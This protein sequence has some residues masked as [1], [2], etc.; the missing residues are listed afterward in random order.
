ML[1]EDKRWCGGIC[2]FDDD[3][4]GSLPNPTQSVYYHLAGGTHSTFR[5]KI[6][7]K[8]GLKILAGTI[9]LDFVVIQPFLYWPSYYAVKAIGF[10]SDDN[11][12]GVTSEEEKDFYLP[13]H[14]L[15]DVAF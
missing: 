8:A 12:D 10:G 3:I 14:R 4:L 5:Q 2:A 1:R 13:N 9:A 6:K 15:V 11:P 7:D